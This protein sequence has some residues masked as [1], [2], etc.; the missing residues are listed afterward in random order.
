MTRA[1]R[2]V[3]SVEAASKAS[4]DMARF[5][6]LARHQMAALRRDNALMAAL[7]D[8]SEKNEAH[9][10][11]AAELRLQRAM[12]TH[13]DQERSRRLRLATRQEIQLKEMFEQACRSERDWLLAEKQVARAAAESRKKAVE[14]MPHAPDFGAQDLGRSNRIPRRKRSLVVGAIG[15]KAAERR[16]QAVEGEKQLLNLLARMSA[17]EEAALERAFCDPLKAKELRRQ[18]AKIVIT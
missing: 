8:V 16:A 4:T 12:A 1:Q 14:P 3:E 15:Q 18:L 10:L 7:R 2:I 5:H 13:A 9:H 6:L 11:R 17:D